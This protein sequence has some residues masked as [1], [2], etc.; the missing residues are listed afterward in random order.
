MRG[1]RDG[2]G[3][4]EDEELDMR[5]QEIVEGGEGDLSPLIADI[6]VG[7]D[8]MR[9]TELSLNVTPGGLSIILGRS[10]TANS[11]TGIRFMA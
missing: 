7:T 1:G 11:K 4:R 10:V 6:E 5:A 9:A 8:E 2:L 3:D